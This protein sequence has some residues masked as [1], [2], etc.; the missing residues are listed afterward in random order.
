MT[1]KTSYKNK[2]INSKSLLVHFIEKSFHHFTECHL[3]KESFELIA[4]YSQTPSDRKM[5]LPKKSKMVRKLNLRIES[6]DRNNKKIYRKRNE[7]YGN[8]ALRKRNYKIKKRKE[9]PS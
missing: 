8:E 4:I 6:F 7:N 9:E 2:T 5:I 3:T 1:D